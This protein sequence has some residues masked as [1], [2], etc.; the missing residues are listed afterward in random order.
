M[1]RLVVSVTKESED[2][3]RINVY[4]APKAMFSVMCAK[5][6]QIAP[7]LAIQSWGSMV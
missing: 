3:V 1:S 4:F 7:V 6:G 2:G 5:S